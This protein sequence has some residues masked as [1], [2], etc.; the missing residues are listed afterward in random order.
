LGWITNFGLS[1]NPTVHSEPHF[2]WVCS[3]DE[4][5][6]TASTPHVLWVVDAQHVDLLLGEPQEDANIAGA[7][8]AE[9][10]ADVP[11]T[12]IHVGSDEILRDDA[13]TEGGDKMKRSGCDV[14]LEV[15]PKLPHVCFSTLDSCREGRAAMNRIGE[16]LQARI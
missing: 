6:M 12:L 1:K 15:W 7:L 16:F 13:R 4:H 5:F 8:A 14:D 9:S 11:S 3:E 10:S 2:H